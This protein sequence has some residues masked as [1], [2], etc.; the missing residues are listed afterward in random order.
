MRI[1]YPSARPRID[2]PLVWEKKKSLAR[3][4]RSLVTGETTVLALDPRIL[5]QLVLK[6]RLYDARVYGW[7]DRQTDS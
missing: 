3:P 1:V 4:A 5:C 7:M 2:S 6:F